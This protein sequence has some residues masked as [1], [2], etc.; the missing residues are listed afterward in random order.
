M[1][2]PAKTPPDVDRKLHEETAKALQTP[3]VR[4]KFATMGGEAMTMTAADSTPS[5]ATRSR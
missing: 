2:V 3:S 4:D 5:S 1:F